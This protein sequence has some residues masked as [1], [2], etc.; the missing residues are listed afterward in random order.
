[1]NLLLVLLLLLLLL[2]FIAFGGNFSLQSGDTRG[3]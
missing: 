2:C 1:L 3:R